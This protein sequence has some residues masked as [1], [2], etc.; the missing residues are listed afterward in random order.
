MLTAVEGGRDSRELE[1][2][3]GNHGDGGPER[4]ATEASAEAEKDVDH[5]SVEGVA[6]KLVEEQV[7]GLERPGED[8]AGDDHKQDGRPKD[9]VGASLNQG[10]AGLRHGLMVSGGWVCRKPVRIAWLG[11]MR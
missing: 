7:A 10:L 4:D 11:D 8:A 5:R 3:N 2:L 9:A 1:A 6:E